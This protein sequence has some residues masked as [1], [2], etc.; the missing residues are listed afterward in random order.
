MINPDDRETFL[1]ALREDPSFRDAVRRELLTEELLS[2]PQAVAANT[3]QIADLTQAVAEL[4]Q[5]L[6]EVR[7]AIGELRAT[8]G[9]LVD[10]VAQQRQ[11]FDELRATMGA[12]VDAVAQQRQDFGELTTYV[13]RYMVA[14]LDAL[15]DLRSAMQAGFEELRREIG[16]R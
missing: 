5:G 2:L 13:Q 14:T 15:N 4:R 10:A 12:L 8:T 11:E 16:G 6:A 9:A 3:R 1:V 7:D